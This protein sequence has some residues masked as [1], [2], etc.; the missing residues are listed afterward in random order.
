MNARDDI[1]STGETID[2]AVLVEAQAESRMVRL[3]SVQRRLSLLGQIIAAI[4]F[5]AALLVLGKVAMHMQASRGNAWVIVPAMLVGMVAVGWV[6]SALT[7]RRRT[8]RFRIA[9]IKRG[10]PMCVECGYSLRGLNLAVASCPEC[11]AAT[12]LPDMTNEQGTHQ[13]VSR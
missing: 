6:H 2:P 3:P 8:R 13:E 7:H 10:V 11:G 12:R 1:S 4:V 9:L 5:V